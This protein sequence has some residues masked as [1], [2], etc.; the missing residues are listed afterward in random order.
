V[1]RQDT[2]FLLH[3][4]EDSTEGGGTEADP[5]EFHPGLAQFAVFHIHSSL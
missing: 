1:Y 3:R 4:V 2:F 5:G